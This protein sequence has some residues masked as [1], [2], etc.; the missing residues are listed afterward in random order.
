[1]LKCL[2]I[3]IYLWKASGYWESFNSEILKLNVK[4]SLLKIAKHTDY[5]VL[6]NLHVL[7]CEAN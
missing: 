6:I 4:L 1:M 3:M 7:S 5:F 2:S